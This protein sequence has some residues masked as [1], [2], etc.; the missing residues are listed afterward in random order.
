MRCEL[1]WDVVLKNPDKA[2]TWIFSTDTDFSLSSSKA[3]T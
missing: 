2:F 1:E 3:F